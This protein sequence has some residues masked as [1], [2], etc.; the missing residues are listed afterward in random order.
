M[1]IEDKIQ[2]QIDNA[3]TMTTYTIDGKKY[4]TFEADWAYF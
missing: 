2:K 1:I 4:N 3:S